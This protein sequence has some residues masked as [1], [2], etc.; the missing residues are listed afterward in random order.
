MEIVGFVRQHRQ[1]TKLTQ[2]GNSNHGGEAG[3]CRCHQGKTSF[4]LP[5]GKIPSDGHRLI[6]FGE[7]NANPLNRHQGNSFPPKN[8]LLT[9]PRPLSGVL[10]TMSHPCG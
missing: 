1:A 2:R 6:H 7:A 8:L 5:P 10:T 4:G 9:K 3:R